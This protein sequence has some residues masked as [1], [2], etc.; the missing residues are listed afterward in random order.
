MH[1]TTI[2]T[3]FRRIPIDNVGRRKIA[4]IHSTARQSPKT[5][6]R[7]RH[8]VVVVDR[9]TSGAVGWLHSVS[10]SRSARRALFS[11]RVGCTPYGAAHEDRVMDEWARA[12]FGRAVAAHITHVG[13]H[14]SF[15]FMHRLLTA[16][17]PT[18]S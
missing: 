14:R 11:G 13:R 10:P 1:V 3:R 4:C 5:S 12:S 16:S 2:R 18:G 7:L 8:G 6:V 17:H 15:V 9:E